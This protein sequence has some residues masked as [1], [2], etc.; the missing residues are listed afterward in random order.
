MKKVVQKM[1]NGV[2]KTK[3]GVRK[4]KMETKKCFNHQ[5]GAKNMKF[6]KKS[7]WRVKK[8]VKN[9]KIVEKHTSEDK[10]T[11][12]VKKFTKNTNLD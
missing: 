10:N 1:K 12:F 11:H 7:E 5:V 2:K 8:V 3:N 6:Y 4:R 9:I